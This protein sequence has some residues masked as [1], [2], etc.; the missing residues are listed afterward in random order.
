M[1]RLAKHL[2]ENGISYTLVGD[3]YIPDIQL[4]ADEEPHYGRYGRLRAAYL[5]EHRPALYQELLMDGKL[6]AHL[7]ATD[8]AANE[9]RD[10]ITCRMAQSQHIDEGLKARDQLGWVR[11]MNAIRATAEELILAELIYS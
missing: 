5:Q 1:N 7:N 4:P 8:D 2:T 11:S 9:R 3:Y 6:V 10:N